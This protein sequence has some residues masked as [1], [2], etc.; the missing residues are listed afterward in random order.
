M[1]YFFHHNGYRIVDRALKTDADV[2]F[3]NAWGAC[4]ADMF[5]WA[6][7]EADADHA[8]GKPFHLYCMTTSNHRPF[9]FPET[10]VD[11]KDSAGKLLTDGPKRTVKYTDHAIHELI[12]SARSKPWFANTV[13]VIVADHCAFSDGKAELDVTKFHIPALIWNPQLVQPQR[14]TT[15]ASQ[16]DVMPTLF[17]LMNW[18]YT[19][20]FFGQDVL[21]PEYGSHARA[22]ISN[23]QKIALMKE[24]QLAILKPVKEYSLYDVMRKTGEVT[25]NAALT[26][27]LETAIDYY[28]SASHLYEEGRMKADLSKP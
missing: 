26:P 19:T 24:D 27:L 8:A 2:T 16:I 7:A 6:M 13:F 3:E 14:F 21:D 9:T 18:S 10:G 4:D 20:R 1:N 12:E 22:F 15:L 11:L 5:R 23:Y 25:P 28:Q 17:G